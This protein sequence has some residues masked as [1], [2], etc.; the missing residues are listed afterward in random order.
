MK[1]KREPGILL[2]LPAETHK[3]LE[4]LWSTKTFGAEQAVYGFLEIRKSLV[5][6]LFGRFTSTEMIFLID[7]FD[8]NMTIPKVMINKKLFLSFIEFNDKEVNASVNYGLNINE[9]IDK[10][11]QMLPV[12][13]YFLIDELRFFFEQQ[14]KGKMNTADFI[15]QKLEIVQ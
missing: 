12:E 13:I 4:K 7:T 11:N 8:Y 9:L 5:N 1:T 15:K 14:E 10:V 6:E 2:H 3:T